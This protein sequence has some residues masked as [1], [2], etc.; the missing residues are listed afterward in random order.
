M[1][2]TR[3]ATWK[4][5]DTA[6]LASVLYLHQ[7]DWVHRLLLRGNRIAGVSVVG[8]LE[9]NV[10]LFAPSTLIILAG[11]LTLLDSTDHV[12]SVLTDLP[13]MEE[14]GRGLLELKLLCLVVVSVYASFTPS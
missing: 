2:Y 8:S 12:V 11:T 9:R 14:T 10:S 13:F 7:K 3:Y 1:D 4:G 6:C 5:C